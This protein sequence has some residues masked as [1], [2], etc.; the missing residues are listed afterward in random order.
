MEIDHAVSLAAG[1]RMALDNEALLSAADN[2]RKGASGARPAAPPAFA[3]RRPRD[4]A[5]IGA[6][7]KRLFAA[8]AHA[9][10]ASVDPAE[11]AD[12]ARRFALRPQ[13][14]KNR[15]DW[16]HNADDAVAV[17]LAAF[18]GLIPPDADDV[19]RRAVI[20]VA[21]RRKPRGRMHEET[22]YAP[23]VTADGRP[24][25]AA[26]KAVIDLT[27]GDAA[28]V[29]DARLGAALR[30]CLAAE[31]DR[32]AALA[33]FSRKTGVRRLRLI[34][35]AADAILLPQNAAGAPRRAVLPKS[36]YAIDLVVLRDGVWRA[37]GVTLHDRQRK[38]WRPQWERLRLGGKLAMRLCKGDCVEIDSEE[39]R[40]VLRVQRLAPSNGYVW[41][42]G[43]AEAS[44]LGRR[45]ADP[46]DP[47]RFVFLSA[48]GMQ[49]RRARAV[50]IDLLGIARPRR[51]NVDSASLSIDRVLS[52]S[53]EPDP[54]APETGRPTATDSVCR[55]AAPR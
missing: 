4:M 54:E 2:R 32:A 1:G 52:G 14:G 21:P 7:L 16:R 9:P 39:G 15:D 17:A 25:A 41:L 3:R 6:G 5:L 22:L 42:A 38:D 48:R 26:R 55:Q 36:N 44:D 29:R 28:H 19:R 27:A 50:D 51:T 31:S 18:P 45:H 35:P 34:R 49:Q 40:R 53:G 30:E 10:A 20:S 37:F 43:L 23:A 13:T 12:A 24:A 33:E 46:L 47:F 11:V 8:I